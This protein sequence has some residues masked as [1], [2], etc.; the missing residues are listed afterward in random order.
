[1]GDGLVW[2]VLVGEVVGEDYVWCDLVVFGEVIDIFV[3]FGGMYV[4]DVQVECW[5]DFEVW[6]YVDCGNIIG[7][8]YQGGDCVVVDDFVFWVVDDC[9]VVGQVQGQFFFVGGFDC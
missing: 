4:V 1:M 7:G 8:V 9:L 2:I 6:Q 3:W 5:V